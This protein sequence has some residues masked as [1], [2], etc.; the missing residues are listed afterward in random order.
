MDRQ[1]AANRREERKN[2]VLIKARPVSASVCVCV[3]VCVCVWV[4]GCV[5]VS[6]LQDQTTDE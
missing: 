6:Q 3:F 2:A 5:R 1:Q 4:G